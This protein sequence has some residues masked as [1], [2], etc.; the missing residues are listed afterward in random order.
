MKQALQEEELSSPE[1]VREILSTDI[2][3]LRDD[4]QTACKSFRETCRKEFGIE[5]LTDETR[6]AVE[7]LE[8]SSLPDFR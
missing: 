3:E 4:Y 2:E 1:I 6:D 5:A 7:Q 8:A